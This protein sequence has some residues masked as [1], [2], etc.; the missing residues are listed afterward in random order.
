ML[1]RIIR[2]RSALST[3]RAFS[4]GHHDVGFGDVADVTKVHY[5]QEFDQGL[6]E[7]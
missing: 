7:E 1:S 5:T 3:V 4:S 2:N 6:T